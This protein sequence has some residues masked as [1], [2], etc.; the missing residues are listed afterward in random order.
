MGQIVRPLNQLANLSLHLRVLCVCVRLLHT[1]SL[2]F[3]FDLVVRVQ[4]L[5]Q[6][7]QFVLVLQLELLDE[8]PLLERVENPQ[9]RVQEQQ[10]A[11]R[12]QALLM[13]CY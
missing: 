2:S 7:H 10:L 13:L 12:L 3:Y 4:L 8:L 6:V 1:H 9:V 11:C 5:Y